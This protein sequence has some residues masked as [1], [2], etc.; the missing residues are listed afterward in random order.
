M[1]NET[2]TKQILELFPELNGLIIKLNRMSLADK[3]YYRE[4]LIMSL[5]HNTRANDGEILA[6]LTRLSYNINKDID[7]AQKMKYR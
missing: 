3:E 6:A 2:M 4:I 1:L 5:L 7:E